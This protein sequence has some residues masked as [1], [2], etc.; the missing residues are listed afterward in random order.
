[1]SSD[2]PLPYTTHMYLPR[3]P[4]LMPG[5]WTGASVVVRVRKWS[6]VPHATRGNP[7][8]PHV[9]SSSCHH[10]CQPLSQWW[11]AL[12]PKGGV[13][14][15][16]GASSRARTA[17]WRPH[18]SGGSACRCGYVD[19]ARV[20]RAWLWWRYASVWRGGG[21]GCSGP[22]NLIWVS[23]AV[24]TWLHLDARG[25]AARVVELISL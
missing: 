1:L 23:W 24:G 3:S 10:C 14:P 25:V 21:G 8:A 20:G 15:A 17:G 6:H 13:D 4:W 2:E 22:L 7:S 19:D 16:V 12:S 18:A 11:R 5:G 9:D